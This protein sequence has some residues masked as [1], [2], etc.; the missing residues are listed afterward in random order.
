MRKARDCPGLNWEQHYNGTQ[1][2]LF[3]WTFL[4]GEE[5]SI[6][7]FKLTELRHE[8]DANLILLMNRVVSY[9]GPKQCLSK[10]KRY[11]RLKME[12]PP[13]IT[14]SQYVGL[15]RDLNSRMA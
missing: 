13:K 5:L 11:I 1:P 12:K 14:T 6:F 15:V 8:T 7:N 3:T 10:Q 9:F 2:V 4:D